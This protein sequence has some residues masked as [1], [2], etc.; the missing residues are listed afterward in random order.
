MVVAGWEKRMSRN[1]RTSH[2]RPQPRVTQHVATAAAEEKANPAF[3]GMTL[4]DGVPQPHSMDR[5]YK[6]Y[7]D[8]GYAANDS[9]YKCCQYILTNGAAIPP[10]LYT[11]ASMET[12]IKSHPILDRLAH[13]N[14]EQDGVT[15]REAIIGWYLIAGNAF[16][17]A[18]R[19]GKTTGA[20]D[21]LWV[22]EA[23]KVKPIP[24]KTRGISGYQ[25]D[26]FDDTLNP[27]PAANVGHLRTW[28]PIDPIFGLSPIQVAA[29]MI[30]Q[31]NAARKW[32]LALLSNMAKPS[33]A[34][35]VEA[36]IGKQERDQLEAKLAE[37]LAGAR[38]AGRSPV[39]DGGAKWTQT[40]LPPSELDWLK[41]LQYNA[42]QI[43]N[44]YS[45]PPQLIG[46][47]SATT[48]NNMEQAKEASYT[49]AIFPTLDKLYALLTMWLIPMYPDLCDAKGKP[50]AFLYYDK[51]TV[52]VVQQVIQARETAK[53][54]RAI[55]AYLA[56]A[57]TLNQAQEMQGLPALGPKGE[58]YRIGLVLVPADKLEDYAEQSLAAPVTQ[59]KPEHE[60][61]LPGELPPPKPGEP[62]PT[63]P[64]PAKPDDAPPTPKKPTPPDEPPDDTPPPKLATKPK[65]SRNDLKAFRE[66][67]LG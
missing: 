6:S 9:V 24:T 21:E 27:I 43:A 66:E 55:K 64:P 33:G 37:K 49:E 58:V 35:V 23:T 51:D 57:I 53:G 32:N 67:T 65:K 3:S 26:D 31:Q 45:M 20:P 28:N 46:D 22:L 15:F 56:G 59:A 19:P 48:Y 62:P 1:R 50:K 2:Q 44:V 16:I 5:N 61:S 54:D 7:A 36:A 42:G 30:D 40:S 63:E 38:N 12:E 4:F 47:T 11:D 8:Q 29:L 10:K 39:L 41:S 14:N 60:G 34:W 18:I 17:Y 13:P 25:F 52:E